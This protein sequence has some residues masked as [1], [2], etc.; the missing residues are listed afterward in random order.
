VTDE[1]DDLDEWMTTATQT[2]RRKQWENWPD[3]VHDELRRILARNDRGDQA[4]IPVAAVLVRLRDV[5]GITCGDTT[6]F[7]YVTQH[8]GR[9]GWRSP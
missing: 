9:K 8:L 6:L 5:H 3:V 4:P 2:R 7:R 1:A